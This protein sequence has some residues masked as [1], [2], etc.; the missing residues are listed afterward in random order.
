MLDPDRRDLYTII[1]WESLFILPK[2]VA[3]KGNNGK[4]LSPCS[5]KGHQYLHFSSSSDITDPMV[6]NEVITPPNGSRSHK[7]S[8]LGQIL[9]AQQLELDLS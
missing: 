7:V 1:D 2:C 6:F 5:I 8:S 9:G 4:Y 3:F